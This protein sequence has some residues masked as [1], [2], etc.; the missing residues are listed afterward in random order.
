M[1]GGAYEKVYSGHL[2]TGDDLDSD[3]GPLCLVGRMRRFI[4]AN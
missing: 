4:V 1:S 2:T 3:L